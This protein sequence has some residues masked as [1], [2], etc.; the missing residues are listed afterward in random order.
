MK[1]KLKCEI[2]SPVHIGTGSEIEPFDYIIKDNKFYKISL[3]D[4]LL[5]LTAE[6]QAEFNKLLDTTE[7]NRI[8]EFITRHWNPKRCPP[9][10]SADVS[11]EVIKTYN[12]NI[13]NIENQLL[14][15]P[16]I[17]TNKLPYVPGS[18]LKGAI[19][20]A[21]ISELASET[22]YIK[23]LRN[24]EAEVLKCQ[25]SRGRLDAKKDPFRGVRIKDGHLPPNATIISKVVNVGKDKNGK[26]K[27]LSIQMFNE[28]TYSCLSGKP[29]E[30]ETELTIDSNLQDTHW[31]GKNIN[32][33]SIRETCNVFYLD[34]LEKEKI[35]YSGT[36]IEEIIS[37]LSKTKF[38]ENYFLVRIGRYS[39][40]E[41]VTIDKYRKPR[42]PG[43]KGWGK[44]KNLSDL[45]Y[46]LGWV[47][48]KFEE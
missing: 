13:D 36:E 22:N 38:D 44:T 10:Y 37:P 19:R 18:S 40:V 47:K 28:V 5:S 4:F 32:I 29:L 34:K 33:E 21:I 23:D 35:F 11:D 45:K 3:E 6:E 17:R 20:T 1:Y 14:I 43:G 9:E 12:E 31:L 2:L 41:S 30:F 25:T 7:I 15:N 8:R 27:P 46:P 39:G 16:F 24:I 48:I 26:L 42:P